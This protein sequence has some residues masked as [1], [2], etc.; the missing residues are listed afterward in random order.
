MFAP[1]FIALAMVF[2]EFSCWYIY[3]SGLLLLAD[4]M[5]QGKNHFV[6]IA[7]RIEKAA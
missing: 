5:R 2:F 7:S 1:I 6:T 4:Y 3:A